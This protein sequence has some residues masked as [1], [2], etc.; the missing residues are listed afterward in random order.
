MRVSLAETYK[1]FQL[2]LAPENQ[3]QRYD[4]VYLQNQFGS[5]RLR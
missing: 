3:E 2:L 4:A 1:S 5:F